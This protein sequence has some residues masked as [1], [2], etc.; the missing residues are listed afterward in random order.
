M[1]LHTDVLDLGLT[2]I[3]EATALHLCSAEPTNRSTAI[4]L[5]LGNKTTPVVSAPGDSSGLSII[6][7]KVTISSV[8][9]GAGTKNGDATYWAL[10][11]GSRLLAAQ[12]DPS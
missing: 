11:D 12:L 7:R 4:S 6:G 5:S 2:E 3:T 10:I 1:Y 8:S 9:D